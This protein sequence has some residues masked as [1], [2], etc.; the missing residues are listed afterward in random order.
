VSDHNLSL[1]VGHFLSQHVKRH[2]LRLSVTRD[3]SVCIP[4]MAKEITPDFRMQI[5]FRSMPNLSVKGARLG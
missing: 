4:Q 1:E 3:D 5:S 2:E